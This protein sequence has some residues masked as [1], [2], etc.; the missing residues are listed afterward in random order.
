[1]LI[2]L[3][4]KIAQKQ[5]IFNQKTILFTLISFFAE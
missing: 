2:N 5:V 4:I 1:M 3:L